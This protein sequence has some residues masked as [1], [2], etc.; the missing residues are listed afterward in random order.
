MRSDTKRHARHR[1]VIA[2]LLGLLIALAAAAGA[3]AKAAAPKTFFGMMPQ[4][5]V[6]A[7]DI[8]HMGEANVGTLRLGIDWASTDPTPGD[9]Y[10]FGGFDALV[11]AAAEQGIEILPFVAGTPGWN[12]GK[13]LAHSL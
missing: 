2:T 8:A 12:S 4:T 3:H 10:N 9:D 6:A 13:W 7:S 1:A 5:N 11:K